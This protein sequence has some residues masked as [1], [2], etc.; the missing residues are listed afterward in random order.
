[1][2]AVACEADTSLEEMHALIDRA[3]KDLY[4]KHPRFEHMVYNTERYPIMHRVRTLGECADATCGCTRYHFN[5]DGAVDFRPWVRKAFQQT[6]L[7]R[8]LASHGVPSQPRQVRFISVGAGM[9]LFEF[10][11]LSSLRQAGLSIESAAFVDTAYGA[12]V[13]RAAR[14]DTKGALAELASWLAP[15]SVNVYNSVRALADACLRGEESQATVL[16]QVDTAFVSRAS[17]RLLAAASLCP[18]G[19]AFRLASREEEAV[20]AAAIIDVWKRRTTP[21][22]VAWEGAWK[23][24][25]PEPNFDRQWLAEN[26]LLVDSSLADVITSET[27]DSRRPT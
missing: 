7:S 22:S 6:V 15:A 27:I 16:V 12:T 3:P 26:Q 19:L 8:T 4:A 11:L 24:L 13:G 1:M 10:E 23:A 25:S 14:H 18:E 20:G 2:L 5:S 9:L 21:S 17:T